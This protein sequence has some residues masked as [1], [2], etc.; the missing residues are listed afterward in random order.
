MLPRR[1]YFRPGDPSEPP[2][3]TAGLY[4]QVSVALLVVLALALAAAFTTEV[5]AL[6]TPL[7]TFFI[8]PHPG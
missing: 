8:M 2:L 3:P 7:D 4:K 5:V 6:L 1:L